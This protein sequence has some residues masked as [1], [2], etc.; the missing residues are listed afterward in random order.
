MT[1]FSVRV[2]SN[3][4]A[5]GLSD[6]IKLRITVKNISL[7]TVEV[8][9]GSPWREVSIAIEDKSG[10]L[11]PM[12]GAADTVTYHTLIGGGAREIKPGQTVALQWA[13]GEWSTLDHWGYSVKGAGEY[14][15]RA[16]PHLVGF[17]ATADHLSQTDRF[18]TG[19]KSVASS[20][21]RIVL[22]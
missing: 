3:R 14:T 8:F 10:N 16:V 18:V 6:L 12:S 1:F 21:I 7:R 15:V 17:V 9:D 22:R 20:G 19:P 13:D 2:E 4:A 5:Y 11:V